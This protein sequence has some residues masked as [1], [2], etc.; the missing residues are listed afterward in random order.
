MTD[1][2]APKKAGAQKGNNFAV[3]LKDRAS[4]QNAYDALCKWIADGWAYKS[5]VFYYDG[6][7]MTGEGIYEMVKRHPDEFDADKIEVANALAYQIWERRVKES[8]NGENPHASTATLQMVMRV[9]FGWDKRDGSSQ[10]EVDK[11]K[12]R[13][14]SDWM[15]KTFKEARKNA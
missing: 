1:Q 10:S 13:F 3:K 2:P 6:G 8:A 15:D 5:F 9:K 4:R 11:E 12:F 14:L 7:A